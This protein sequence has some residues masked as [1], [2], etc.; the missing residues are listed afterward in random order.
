M[1][2]PTTA[3][4][5]GIVVCM[6]Q[7]VAVHVVFCQSV[8]MTVAAYLCQCSS[9]EVCACISAG[10]HTRVS[11]QEVVSLQSGDDCG[12]M[13]RMMLLQRCTRLHDT[14]HDDAFALLLMMWLA[15]ATASC[16]PR[17]CRAAACW[18]LAIR[19]LGPR[20]MPSRATGTTGASS[21]QP[22]VPQ[23]ACG[24]HQPRPEATRSAT[25]V[26]CGRSSTAWLVA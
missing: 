20:L 9:I 24:I 12:E 2:L 11:V 3:P 22:T 6:V 4:Q 14:C 25:A 21:W 17:L 13:W 15:N 1:T 16:A 26:T 8:D 23:L 18:H 19:P 7:H 10:E 5:S